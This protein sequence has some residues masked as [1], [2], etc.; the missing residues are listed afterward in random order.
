MLKFAHFVQRAGNVIVRLFCV[1][2]V[3]RNKLREK[4]NQQKEEKAKKT[5]ILT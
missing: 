1:F 4:I 5:V 2:F 3:G